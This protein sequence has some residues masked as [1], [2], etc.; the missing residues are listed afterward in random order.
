MMD[1]KF[2]REH[3]THVHVTNKPA[4]Q[5]ESDQIDWILE[6]MYTAVARLR[7]RR[8]A[9]ADAIAAADLAAAVLELREQL[10]GVVS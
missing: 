3:F 4:R 6:S 2:F 5:V 9:T 10:K 7:G 8:D 1:A